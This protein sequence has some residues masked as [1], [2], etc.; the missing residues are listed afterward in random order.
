MFTVKRFDAFNAESSSGSKDGPVDNAKLDALNERILKKR[1]AVHGSEA[2]GAQ[3]S[4]TTS[5]SAPPQAAAVPMPSAPATRPT[6]NI[7]PSRLSV[8]PI[9][10][11]SVNKARTGPKEKTKA[12]QRYLKAK[13][14]RRKARQRAAPKR[15]KEDA[16]AQASAVA[17]NSIVS[18]LPEEDAL[19]RREATKKKAAVDADTRTDERSEASSSSGSDS[20]SSEDSGSESEQD[21]SDD[22]ESVSSSHPD[23]AIPEAES[24]D[25]DMEVEADAERQA[26]ALERF[27]LAGVKKAVD[28]KLIRSLGLPEGLSNRTVVNPTLSQPIHKPASSSKAAMNSK[29]SA[30]PPIDGGAFQD[31]AEASSDDQE[32]V[33]ISA[34]SAS[35][36]DFGRVALNDTVRSRLEALGV[37]EWFAVQ[38]SVIPCLLAQPQSRSLYRPFAP[39]RD[40]CVSAPTGSGKTLAYSVPIVEVLRT[41]QIVQLRALIVLPTR[42]LV[43]QVRSTLELVAKGSGLRIGTATGQHSFAHEQ[44]QLVGPSDSGEPD[45]ED[46]QLEAKID[47]LIATPGRLID[48][49][50]STPG[51]TLAHLRFLVIDEADRLLNQS[52]QE[53]LRRVLSATE[54]KQQNA[55]G[56][57]AQQQ[58]SAQAPYELLSS[59][60][61]GLGAAAWSTLQ[62]EAG[63]SVQKLLFS[64]TLTRDPAKIAALGLRNPHYITVQDSHSVGDEEDERRNGA[65]QHER[66]SLPHSLREH[67]LVT[68]SADK[69]FHLLYL[70]H[71]PDI[72]TNV[73]RI[74][75]ALCFTKSVDSAARLVKLV[76]I[77]EEV[78]S[79]NGLIARGSRPLVVKNYSSELKPSDRQRILT[80]FSQGE[81][82]FLVCSDLISRGIDLPSVEHV[83]SYDAPIDPAKYV[84]RVGRTARA[85]K[86]GDAWTL[87]EEQEA[88]HFKKMVQ[89]IARQTAIAKV[90]PMKHKEDEVV[91][92]VEGDAATR[93]LHKLREAYEEALARMAKLYRVQ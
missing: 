87:V 82:N 78:R 19:H 38:M 52:F 13:K 27:P 5:S 71:R 66:F 60:A 15:S 47:I 56:A 4:A 75:K 12:K 64:A 37:S 46:A 1:K 73:S 30:T 86:H 40:L 43:A 36:D 24:K 34:S 11:Q 26:Q 89:S 54:A 10:R 21:G 29:A 41:R 84:H 35:N 9:L 57:P 55:G 70:L 85:G 33:T 69:P 42:D 77:F 16:A 22:S 92:F 65:Q 23:E 63:P 14:D 68:T 7:H 91:D 90:K 20:D 6:L 83:I 93:E 28:P 79:E 39:P 62:E 81:I 44:N 67:M 80:A 61:S 17:D 3:V 72:E 59:S 18:H 51:F 49:L 25:V 58:G 8:A 31:M 48:H 50:D 74:R 76:E 53:W 88:R 32:S 2:S 45:E